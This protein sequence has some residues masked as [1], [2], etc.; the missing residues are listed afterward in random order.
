MGNEIPKGFFS[1]LAHLGKADL[2][3]T[4]ELAQF[5]LRSKKAIKVLEDDSEDQ[6]I[7]DA[8]VE[9][10]RH[11]LPGTN[12]IPYAKFRSSKTWKLYREK[13]PFLTEFVLNNFSDFNR[14]ERR[15]LYVVLLG[16]VSDFL[17]ENEVPLLLTTLI[18]N[19]SR[20]PSLFEKEFPGYLASGLAQSIIK[21]WQRTVDPS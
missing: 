12:T 15:A 11:Y 2:E 6:L 13:S 4:I 19:L 20:V 3:K 21:R 9:T 10:L 1:T 8:L 7:Y 14:T 17:K 16:M 18:N 5:K